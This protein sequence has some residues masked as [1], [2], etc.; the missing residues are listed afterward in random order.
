MNEWVI[1]ISDMNYD[2]VHMMNVWWLMVSISYMIL[3]QSL[4]NGWLITWNWWMGDLDMDV[5]CMS[6]SHVIS[7]WQ[8]YDTMWTRHRHKPPVDGN[9][10]DATWIYGDDW[11]MVILLPTSMYP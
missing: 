1:H 7:R 2:I 5:G 3:Y 9:G 6:D 11:G 10:K 4:N 8:I